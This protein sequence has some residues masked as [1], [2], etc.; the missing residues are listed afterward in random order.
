MP[1]SMLA[2]LAMTLVTL[3]SF[4]QQKLWVKAHQDMMRDE[5]VMVAEGVLQQRMAELGRDTF[6]QL[7]TRHGS[8][9]QMKVETAT[10]G[11]A[12]VFEVEASIEPVK[13]SGQNW[14]HDNSANPTYKEVT[15][16]VRG[17]VDHAGAVR[18]PET[19][20]NGQARGIVHIK[21]I[22]SRKAAG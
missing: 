14:V 11:E 6:D 21:R 19:V 18:L 7:D 10:E 1:Q 8:R 13:L 12:L 15:L 17:P 20:V 4:N 2:L 22:F 5:L 16:Y 3:F 9:R